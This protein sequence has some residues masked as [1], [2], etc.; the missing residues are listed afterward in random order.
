MASAFGHGRGI[1]PYAGLK[2]LLGWHSTVQERS[3]VVPSGSGDQID[4]WRACNQRE[5]ALQRRISE[6]RGLMEPSP[7]CHFPAPGLS[8]TP[9]L[10]VIGTNP[11]VINTFNHG[12]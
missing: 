11:F 6:Y 12:I 1:Q 4:C 8:L 2:P 5:S 10:I 3:G 9:F 7:E